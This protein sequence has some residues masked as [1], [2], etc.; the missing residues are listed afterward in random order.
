MLFLEVD[1]ITC[2]LGPHAYNA[3]QVYPP[4]LLLGGLFPHIYLCTQQ[5]LLYLYFLILI[6]FLS[7]VSLFSRKLQTTITTIL[8]QVIL[9]LGYG[10]DAPPSKLFFLKKSNESGG[11]C[12]K[13]KTCS[14][15]KSKEESHI[16]NF[17][18]RPVLFFILWSLIW[19]SYI[20]FLSFISLKEFGGLSE[21]VKK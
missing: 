20:L 10:P 1:A 6:T 17:C 13:D 12:P 9:L 4:W 2:F 16:R 15:Q 18:W 3:L 8:F 7:L 5:S 11:S 19:S 21:M 14:E